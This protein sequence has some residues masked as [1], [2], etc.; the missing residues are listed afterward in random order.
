MVVGCNSGG[1][2]G[3]GSA[4]SG[5]RM[6]AASSELIPAAA[7]AGPGGS[8]ALATVSDE[9][10]PESGFPATDA[11]GTT[12]HIEM[13]RAYVRDIE[14]DLPDLSLCDQF[15]DGTFSERVECAPGDDKIVIAG[16]F[17]VDLVNA[18]S[19][20]GLANVGLPGGAYQRIDI[21]FDDAET[22]DGLV[23]AEDPLNTN[24]LIM[25]GTFKYDPDDAG[26][27][28]KTFDM[29]LKFN[30]DVR[31]EGPEEDIVLDEGSA[32]DL[33]LRLDVAM[34]FD[35][36]PI[37]TC[38]NDGDLV[39]DENNHLLVADSGGCSTIENDLKEA[40]KTSGQLD[41]N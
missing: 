39:V 3:S 36:L 26:E 9:P 23:T 29:V 1:S 8:P 41:K 18:T 35:A 38:I 6:G 19:T 21:R 16:P 4:E 34:W 37:T 14:L 40:M 28:E 5:V 10:V 27:V 24:T 13:A 17:M 22:A 7:S 2:D 15:E 31:F 30:E 33:V 20:P 25:S 32:E 12:F 11:D